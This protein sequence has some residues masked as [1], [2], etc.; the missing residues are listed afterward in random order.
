MTNSK[1]LKFAGLI[2][3]GLTL[4]SVLDTS[5]DLKFV[6]TVNSEFIIEAHKNARFRDIINKNFATF[7]GQVPFLIA[8][9]Q[10]R[11]IKFAKI[12]GS[13]LI[14]DACAFCKENDKRIFL[15]GGL[16]ESNE[17]SISKLRETYGV[18]I[19]GYSPEFYPYPFPENIEYD[20]LEKITTFRPEFLF[21]GFGIVKQEFWIDDHLHQL[22]D[23]G[24]KWAIGCGGTF[25]I[26]SQKFKRAPLIMQKL[27]IESLFRFMMEPKIFRFKRILKSFLLFKLILRK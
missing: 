13:D 16:K 14:Y 7:D 5:D 15:L 4:E 9:L 23:S 11:A 26:V 12:S 1:E 2:F 10:N 21:V 25:E 22:K 8:R 27:G 3:R 19:F 20:I 6:I 18:D 17:K 24:V